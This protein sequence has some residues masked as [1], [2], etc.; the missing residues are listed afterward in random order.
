M[1]L[2]PLN[3]PAGSVAAQRR[4]WS[5]SLLL[6]YWHLTSLDA[7]TVAV[8]WAYAFAWTARVPLPATAVAPLGLMVWAI[9]IADR[10]LDARA[11]LDKPQRC[12]L[13]ERHRFHWRHRRLLGTLAAA[14][15]VAALWMAGTHLPLRAL[16]RDSLMGVAALAYFSGVHGRGPRSR[17]VATLRAAA[18]RLLSRESIVGIIFSGGCV[19]PVL[20]AAGGLGRVST[21]VVVPFVVFALL[22]WVN[23]YAIEQWESGRDGVAKLALGVAAVLM[24]GAAAL[25]W[26]QPRAAVVLLTAMG[27]ALLLAGLDGMRARVDRVTLRAAADLVLL[28]PLIWLL[29]AA[30]VGR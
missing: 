10:L 1:A 8:A 14:A 27:S 21:V 30:L 9:Y 13:E 6:K 4:A 18:G 19:L 2:I 29:P 16:R 20:S 25:M 26:W 23:L 11:G 3:P 15:G 17:W 24:A 12:R 28:T 7:P 5:G 22:A